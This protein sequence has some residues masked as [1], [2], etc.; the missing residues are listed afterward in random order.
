MIDSAM[1]VPSGF[2]VFAYYL[3][4][5]EMSVRSHVSTSP[6]QRTHRI[7]RPPSKVQTQ[8]AMADSTATWLRVAAVSGAAAVLLGTLSRHSNLGYT[9]HLIT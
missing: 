8:S 6:S 1:R 5:V 4:E 3:L 2:V 9:P 7:L